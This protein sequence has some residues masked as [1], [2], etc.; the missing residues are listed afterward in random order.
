MQEAPGEE[1]GHHWNGN[2]RLDNQSLTQEKVDYANQEH[3][4]QRTDKRQLLKFAL[5][6]LRVIIF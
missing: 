5:K 4:P 3:R 1:G 2:T 6:E